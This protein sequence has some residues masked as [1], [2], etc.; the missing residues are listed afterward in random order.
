[1][2]H[3]KQFK[4]FRKVRVAMMIG[5]MLAGLSASPALAQDATWNAAPGSD[6]WSSGANWSP[7]QVPTA[8]ASF[9]ASSITALRLTQQQTRIGTIRLEAG[10]PAYTFNVL[11]VA[12]NNGFREFTIDGNGIVNNSGNAPTFNVAGVSFGG[13]PNTGTLNFD[14]SATAGNAIIRVN[15]AGRLRFR[16]SGSAGNA[17]ISA[18]LTNNAGSAAQIEFSGAST[19]ATATI[20]A[21]TGAL[22]SFTGTS[23]AGAATITLTGDAGLSFFENASADNA[24][25]VANSTRGV[26][27]FGSSGQPA[28]VTSA[29]NARITIGNGSFLTMDG[30]RDVNTRSVTAGTARI[31]INAGGSAS[32]SRNSTGGD[33]VFDNDGLLAFGFNYSV[34]TPTAGN[35]TITNRSGATT[36]FTNNAT[37]GASTIINETGGTTLFGFNTGVA[38]DGDPYCD[39]NGTVCIATA[40]E[41]TITNNGGTTRFVT[42]ATAANAVI[43]NNNG[44]T[45]IFEDVSTGGN[46]RL[47]NNAG[48][49]IDISRLTAGTGF[50]AGS[51]EGAGAIRLGGRQLTLG[52]GNAS[53]TISGVIS[54][55]GL[56]GGSGGSL[57]KT[58]T[59]T[60]I[61]TGANTYT[62][63]TTVS[64]GTLLVNGSLTSGVTVANGATLGGTGSVGTTN[65][66]GTLSP[67]GNGTIGTFTINGNL[68][69]TAGSTFQAD[70]GNGTADRVNVTGTATLAG[71]FAAF[72]NG[73]TFTNGTYTILNAAGGISG[74]FNPFTTQPNSGGVSLRYDGNNVYLDINSGTPTT[75]FSMS[76]RES[77]LFST[78]TVTTN[79]VSAFS[80]QII[81]RIA[82][83]QPLYDQTFAA[84]FSSL[85]VQNGLTAARAAITAAGGPG[86]IIGDPVR[87]SSATTTATVTG[88]S[89][90]TLTNTQSS[91]QTAITFGPDTIQTGNLSICDVGS[92]PSATRPTCQ[93]GG[94]PRDVAVGETNYNTITNVVYTVAETRTD[95]ITDTLREVYEL[96][97][98]VVAVGT[99]HAEVQSGL[100]DLGSRLLNR[101]TG[102][103]PANAGWGEVYAFRVSQ[104]GRR[105]ARGF[106]VGANVALGQGVTLAFGVDHGSLDID[107]PGAVE[108]GDVTLTEGGAAL[109][110]EQGPFTAA[111]SATYGA[112]NAR[113]SRTVI[114]A[115][116]AKY[117]VRVGG[118]ALDLGY[119]FQAGGWTLRPV[120]G[121]DYVSISTDGFTE[122]DMLGLVVGDQD[123]DRFRASAGL[124][125]GRAWGDFQLAVSA[126]YLTVLN[127]D[128]RVIPV[129][130]ALAPG[131]VLEMTAPNE[132]DTAL[133]GARGR[134]ML[135][136]SV[137]LWAAYDG[138]FGSDYTGHSGMLGLSVAW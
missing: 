47:I 1:M 96:T 79:R 81:G 112:G 41:A 95:T 83:G 107:V 127:G 114:G 88:A 93:P 43:T 36:Q 116:A 98:Q 21:G 16:S 102:P 104:S 132:P 40:A 29:G 53:T 138:R 124:E 113:T 34:G 97:G 48:G 54:D 118:V 19:A 84:A 123:A 130:F 13:L 119:A 91:D 11:G 87:I 42:D 111:L 38:L 101:L 109:R 30:N 68:V 28:N 5:T 31:T 7:G 20:D 37:A 105:D 51:I 136:P 137:S 25:I 86:V 73:A 70:I 90:F 74:T 50:S 8:T 115:S 67:G 106:A 80:T 62:G 39:V 32:F 52:G 100:F 3:R 134:L 77:I 135:S 44:G 122:T 57:V 76:R 9:G 4:A 55:G 12:S 85:M 14:G 103:L 27:F 65:V 63:A 75:S 99:I 26:A 46:A 10:A 125:V 78:P 89:T 82:G 58:G 60:L 72:A 129:A 133:I 108:E 15:G 94:T 61:L 49:T 117:D 17:Q 33:A 64:G 126:R 6:D 120:A 18:A 35:A 71:T 131:N 24:I 59:G 69:L 2:K 110:L 121:L 45:V 128:E 92:L 23:R 66:N 56:G 22:V